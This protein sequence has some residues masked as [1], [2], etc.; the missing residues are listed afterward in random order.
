MINIAFLSSYPLQPNIEAFLYNL[1]RMVGQRFE[2]DLIMGPEDPPPHLVSLFNIYHERA[3]DWE[4]AGLGYALQATNRYLEDHSPALLVNAAQPLP[5][6]VAVILM[7]KLHGVKTLLRVTGN[8]LNNAAMSDDLLIRLRRFLIHNVLLPRVYQLADQIVAIGPDL[9]RDLVHAGFHE[10]KVSAMYQ[11][12]DARTFTP[13]TK[14]R[15]VELKKSLNLDPSRKTI[16]FVGRIRWEKGA[17]RLVNV[18]DNVLEKSKRFQFCLVGEG[19]LRDAFKAYG[20]DVRLPGYVPRK[21]VHKYFKASDLLVHPSR[22][23]GAIPHVVLEALACGVPVIAAPVGEISK[24]VTTTSDDPGDYVSHILSE[25]WS[26][27]P[28]PDCFKWQKQARAYTELLERA[29]S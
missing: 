5:L 17:D 23:E 10:S 4:V 3:P 28:L 20:D 19:P 7:G 1:G 24:V 9:A 27:D 18:I 6:G 12:F 16:L 21:K 13:V 2:L 25:Q 11:P 26:E 22:T 29:A 15:K 14:K 8:F